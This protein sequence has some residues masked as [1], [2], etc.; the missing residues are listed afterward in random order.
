MSV[1][2][3]NREEWCTDARK[4][5]L[6]ARILSSVSAEG[7][8]KK[9]NEAVSCSGAYGMPDLSVRFYDTEDTRGRGSC[10]DR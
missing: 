6:S 1:C 2:G 3:M 4:R 10:G 5:K 9:E 8:E 7:K